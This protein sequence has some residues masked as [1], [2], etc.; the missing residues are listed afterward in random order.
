MYLQFFSYSST[1]QVQRKG[2]ADNVY[3]DANV[4]KDFMHINFVV[5]RLLVFPFPPPH[6]FP[7]ICNLKKDYIR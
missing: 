6:F 2:I 3:C 5:L 4:I 7:L 1:M